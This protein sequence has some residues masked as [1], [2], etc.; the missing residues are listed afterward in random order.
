MVQSGTQPDDETIIVLFD[1]YKRAGNIQGALNLY[2][3]LARSE[4]Q[5]RLFRDT[6]ITTQRNNVTVVNF[7]F[8]GTKVKQLEETA[9]SEEAKASEVYSYL[10]PP[11][12]GT[13]NH[14]LE[15]LRDMGMYKASEEV[16]DDMNE[17]CWRGQRN[18][19][20][21]TQ[22]GR[23]GVSVT[24]LSIGL[25]SSGHGLLESSL[26]Q[27]SPPMCLVSRRASI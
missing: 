2:R 11:S 12:V 7:N 25:T 24:S 4:I 16:I 19:P 21:T 17:R 6:L 10:P 3:N 23:K 5:R 20:V 26:P 13:C 15:I 27:I 22:G 14:L 1:A 18:V 8:A 9:N